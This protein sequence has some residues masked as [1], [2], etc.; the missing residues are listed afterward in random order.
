MLPLNADTLNRRYL[1][2]KTICGPR[3]AWGVRWWRGI[4][5]TGQSVGFPEQRW[6]NLGPPPPLGLAN[7]DEGV[8]EGD[9]PLGLWNNMT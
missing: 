9:C 8:G 1:F 6:T 5:N 4:F 7:D 3:R 2:N